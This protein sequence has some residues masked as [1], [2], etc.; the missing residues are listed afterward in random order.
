DALQLRRAGQVTIVGI[1]GEE[2]A[3]VFDGPRIDFGDLFWTSRRVAA[4]P[5]AEAGRGRRREGILGSGFFR[6]FVVVIDQR[7]QTVALHEPDTFKYSGEG[8]ILPL[9]FKRGGS[10]PILAASLN[11]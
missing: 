5:T 7:A 4:F 9:R 1:A 8:E 6:R 3:S 2:P 10:T 11:A